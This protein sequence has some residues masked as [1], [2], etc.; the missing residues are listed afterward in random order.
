MFVCTLTDDES[1]EQ[2]WI[3]IVSIGKLKDLFA[4]TFNCFHGIDL[5]G[6]FL[7]GGFHPSTHRIIT[8]MNNTLIDQV[9]QL[10]DSDSENAVK[11][12]FCFS[13][14]RLTVDGFAESFKLLSV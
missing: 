1:S 3:K 2:R 12:T 6:F 5:W 11:V 8:D 14:G 13:Q 10:K 9:Q 4:N 7:A